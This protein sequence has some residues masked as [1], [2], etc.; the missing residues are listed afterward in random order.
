IKGTLQIKMPP[1]ITLQ[2]TLGFKG[3]EPDSIGIGQ[4]NLN[5]PIGT[6]GAF[7][8]AISGEVDNISSSSQAPVS[9]TGS[10]TFT[11][12]PAISV[13]LPSFIGGSFTGSALSVTVS[14]TIVKTHLAGSGTVIVAGGIATGSGNFDLDWSKG[15]LTAGASLSIADDLVNIQA[16]LNA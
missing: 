8:Q 16:N 6:T 3:F 5:V 14:A 1:G 10:V 13:S 15:T 2:G 12:G 11:E 9:F 7:L 4:S